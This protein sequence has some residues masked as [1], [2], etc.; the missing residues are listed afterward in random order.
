MTKIALGFFVGI[1]L[2]MSFFLKS[3]QAQEITTVNNFSLNNEH[4]EKISLDQFK[5]KK[6]VVVLF[7]SSNCVWSVR[8]E[9]RIQHLYEAFKDK[10]VA[11]LAV[12]SN[13]PSMLNKDGQTRRT[14]NPFPFPY[15]LDEDQAVAK[16]FK[17]TKNPEAFVL[18]Y[19]QD[20]FQVVFQG[21]IDDNPLDSGSARNN[22]LNE[23]L[24]ALDREQKL[25]E[26][27]VRPSG[28][29]IKWK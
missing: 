26:A 18:T 23:A 4:M 21:K 10:D 22:Y 25:A 20:A 9:E 5:D 7:T 28:C 11:F 27:F 17:A 6:A 14:T 15:L 2:G 3:V 29:N 19:E 12:N 24:A 13:D 8:Y 1:L 16:Q